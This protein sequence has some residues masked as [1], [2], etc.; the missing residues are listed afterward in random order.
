MSFLF[1][2]DVKRRKLSPQPPHDDRAQ[3][4]IYV[5]EESRGTPGFNLF[6][7]PGA[8]AQPPQGPL[9]GQGRGC[10]RSRLRSTL[11]SLKERVLILEKLL[12]SMGSCSSAALGWVGMSRSPCSRQPIH[13]IALLVRGSAIQT[14]GF[15]KGA[16]L[17][18]G[19]CRYGWEAE[20]SAGPAHL[21]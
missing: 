1:N 13:R 9:P 19:S 8:W 2:H 3:A 14:T 7:P 16:F 12:L 15:E 11:A 5:H 17:C 10:R 4:D 21:G 18:G 20:A 6:L